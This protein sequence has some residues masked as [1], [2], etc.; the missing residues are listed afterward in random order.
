MVDGWE[1]LAKALATTGRM[2][3]AI[4]AFG[5]AIEIDPLKPEPHLALARIFALERQPSLARQ[6]AEL[7]I[8]HD[9]GQG[10]EILA[11]LMMDAGRF[12]EAAAAARRSL[13]VD[14]SRYMSRY[15]LGVVAQ[16]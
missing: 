6:H 4:A 9:P 10:Y 7:G 13:Q 11:E 12:D 1:S 8:Q 2:P 16:Q 14:S 15:L 3:E 5:K